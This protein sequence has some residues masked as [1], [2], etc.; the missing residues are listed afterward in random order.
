MFCLRKL[1]FILTIVLCINRFGLTYEC[2]ISTFCLSSCALCE[3]PFCEQP[4]Y[5]KT[6]TVGQ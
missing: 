1:A 2:V 6:V 5:V 4:L 3:I